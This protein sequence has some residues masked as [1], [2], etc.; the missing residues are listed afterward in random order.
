MEHRT[1]RWINT[2]GTNTACSRIF[3]WEYATALLAGLSID[4][5][6]EILWEITKW[7]QRF[8]SIYLYR[9]SVK[10]PCLPDI[11][12]ILS[13]WG[14]RD[15][16]RV[17]KDFQVSKYLTLSDVHYYYYRW[18]RLT[19][20]R[21][22]H[23]DVKLKHDIR[24]A[25]RCNSTWESFQVGDLRIWLSWVFFDLTTSLLSNLVFLNNNIYFFITSYDH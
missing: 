20:C 4:Y 13:L 16:Y 25:F 2:Y 12:V 5:K 21:F 3:R 17:R 11:I 7:Y 10:F 23:H 14:A 18:H 1:L 22:N 24:S 8:G 15:W 6:N 19:S 9:K